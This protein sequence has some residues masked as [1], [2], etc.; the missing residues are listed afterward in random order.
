[1]A[2]LLVVVSLSLVAISG[3]K[4]KA[5]KSVCLKNVKQMGVWHSEF[6]TT[7]ASTR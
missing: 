5:K 6:V 7:G 3:S 4:K 1:M 2:I